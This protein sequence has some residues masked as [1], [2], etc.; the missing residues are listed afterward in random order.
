[1][2]GAEPTHVD[3]DYGDRDI[4]AYRN[5]TVTVGFVTDYSKKPENL[6]VEERNSSPIVAV[7][8][9]LNE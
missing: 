6:V 7:Y 8:M 3:C 2:F 4:Y 1:M 5:S 9:W